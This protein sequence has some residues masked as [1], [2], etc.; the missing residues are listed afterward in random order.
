MSTI[1]QSWGSFLRPMVFLPW[2]VASAVSLLVALQIAVEASEA[3]E[4]DLE[5]LEFSLLQTSVQLERL[6]I[7]ASAAKRRARDSITAEVSAAN[8]SAIEAGRTWRSR[9]SLILQLVMPSEKTAVSGIPALVV[10]MLAA[11]VLVV[12]MIQ[13]IGTLFEQQTDKGYEEAFKRGHPHSEPLFGPDGQERHMLTKP[14]LPP[15]ILPGSARSSAAQG[16]DSHVPSGGRGL[17]LLPSFISPHAEVRFCIPADGVAKLCTGVGPVGVLGGQTRLALLQA[18]FSA[19]RAG[20]GKWLELCREARSRFPHCSAGPLHLE[21][22][23]EA[24][25]IE[26]RGQ[27]GECFAILLEK[28][29][30]GSGWLL[31]RPGGELLMAFTLPGQGKG[32][33]A[34]V[35]GQVS[36]VA[37]TSGSDFQ[38]QVQPGFDPLLTLVCTLCILVQ[39]R[40]AFGL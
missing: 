35:D 26:I 13:I 34:L 11:V 8:R 17:N 31:E 24:S 22:F 7:E 3:H 16:A 5:A 18:R 37:T 33:S 10:F 25:K 32:V 36:A 30:K 28:G 29:S 2:R 1:R 19:D 12:F 14:S 23:L 15:M 9:A 40:E 27:G 38:V 20:G 21:S 4:D 6:P 39:R